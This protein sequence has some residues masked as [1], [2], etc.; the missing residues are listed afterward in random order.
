ME[1][2]RSDSPCPDDEEEVL[3]LFEFA[4][5]DDTNFLERV[6]DNVK[7]A[8]VASA[9]P[10]CK[11]SQMI[12]NGKPSV[13]LGTCVYVEDSHEQQQP[14]KVL[15]IGSTTVHFQLSGIDR[16][17]TRNTEALSHNDMESPSA[18]IVDSTK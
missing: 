13:S 1:S 16:A 14:P 2:A 7:F 12:F 10:T 18:V 5:F 9:Q 8:A 4:D 6:A 17:I 11:I 15:G 3:A